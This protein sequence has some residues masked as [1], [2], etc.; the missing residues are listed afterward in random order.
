[1]GVEITKRTQ[2]FRK[3][4]NESASV[5]K[6]TNPILS[7]NPSRSGHPERVLTKKRHEDTV[8]LPDGVRAGQQTDAGNR[9]KSG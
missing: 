4:A 2:F 9:T 6:K 5:S 7:Q 3:K 1:M 8:I